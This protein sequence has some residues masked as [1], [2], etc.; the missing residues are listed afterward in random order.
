MFSKTKF[1]S[2]ILIVTALVL[3]GCKPQE[4]ATDQKG[5]RL[6]ESPLLT[7]LERKSGL[8][9]YV[10]SDGNIYTV[11]QTGNSPTQITN[12]AAVEG[13]TQRFYQYPT[14]SPDSESLAFFSLSGSSQ[15]DL[16]AAIYVVGKDGKNQVEVYKDDNGSRP[17]YLSW[18]PDSANLTFIATIPSS[19]GLS[20]NMVPAAGGDIQVLD[21][22]SP[23]YWDWRPDG[24]GMLIHSGGARTDDPLA[25]LAFLKL[26][27]GVVE[28]G[29]LLKPATFQSPAF[30]PDGSQLLLAA[31]NDKGGNALI[32]TDLSGEVQNELATFE[33]SVAFG[34]SPDGKNVAFINSKASSFTVGKLNLVEAS[35]PTK[36][37]EVDQE[38]IVAFYWSPDSQKVAYFVP[39][40]QAAVSSS[41]Q[42]NTASDVQLFLKLYVADALTGKST[43][44]WTFVPTQEFLQTML[45]FDQYSRSATIWSPDSQN[46]VVPIYIPDQQAAGLILVPASGNVQPRFL[47]QGTMAFWSWK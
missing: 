34:W 42:D 7:F 32:L 30:S 21:T 16:E 4:Q 44:L 18:S 19:G 2:F 31:E 41:G 35:D 6:P 14:W 26:A 37:I 33:T 5:L 22:G 9:A 20:F 43:L 36:T 8:I 12:D 28:D 13:A 1:L 29:L 11:N 46:L 17:V 10:G 47:Q 39:V 24:S 27:D 45:F 15:T 23:Y 3:A 25:R 40:Q 38:D